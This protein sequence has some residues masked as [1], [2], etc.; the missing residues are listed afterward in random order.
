VVALSKSVRPNLTC[1]S[2]SSLWEGEVREGRGGKE[3]RKKE[4]KEEQGG[5]ERGRKK[6]REGTTK[7]IN[8]KIKPDFSKLNS[9]RTEKPKIKYSRK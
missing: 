1:L 7:I 4:G 5:R 9:G 8:F 3:G 6:G 2:F